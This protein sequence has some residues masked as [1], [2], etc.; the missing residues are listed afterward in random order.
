ML[1]KKLK[2]TKL[3]Y[4]KYVNRVAVHTA[5]AY[6]FREQD[7]DKLENLLLIA[8]ENHGKNE[9]MR[10]L[11]A[12]LW[13]NKYATEKE[14]FSALHLIGILRE[15]K[16]YSLRAEGY[17]LAVFLN[18]SEFVN[19]IKN[20]NNIII[21]EITTPVSDEVKQFLLSNPNT[22]INDNINYKYKVYVKDLGDDAE[23]F[24]IWAKKM[25]NIEA[26]SNDYRYQAHFY[27]GDSKTLGLCRLY[28]GD[29]IRKIE[30]IVAS[31]EI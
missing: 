10:V 25:K 17:T 6:F 21:R 5:L 22:V 23:N 31:H 26:V 16:D 13:A 18:D 2:T 3:F 19:R 20:I 14:V 29:K 27:V 28:L 8:L 1:T 24:V 12:K 7:L 30:E 9:G 15:L 11:I 4:N